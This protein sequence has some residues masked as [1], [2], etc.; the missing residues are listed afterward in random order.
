M[1]I[2]YL[3]G[4]GCAEVAMVFFMKKTNG[5]KKLGWTIVTLFFAAC[6]LMGLSL[7]M[8][9]LNAGV[10]YSIWVSFGSIGSLLI[11]WL[12]YKEKLSWQQLICVIM[13]IG[14]VVGLKVFS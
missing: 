9:T 14:A 4:A 7:S 6:S 1:D 3:V 13:I 8:E 11:G 12:L 2:M 10:A 5:F